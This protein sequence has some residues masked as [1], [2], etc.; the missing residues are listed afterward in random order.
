MKLLTAILLS[1]AAVSAAP[2]NSWSLSS[3]VD[4]VL[5]IARGSTEPGNVV[6]LFTIAYHLWLQLIAFANSAQGM[7]I[8]S[9]L[10]SGLK[11]KYGAKFT[12]QGVGKE[13]GYPA[14][15]VCPGSDSMHQ[16]S[17]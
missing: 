7:I 2:Q 6:C 5:I 13:N 11:Q 10:C 4:N 8:G 1:A 14:A 3:C 9:P 16:A 17:P 15:M 12:C